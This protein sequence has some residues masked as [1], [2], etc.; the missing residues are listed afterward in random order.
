MTE[1]V[2]ATVYA[3]DNLVSY[4][5]TI[6]KAK[7]AVPANHPPPEVAYWELA[8]KFSDPCAQSM[9]CDYLAE[10]LSL[11]VVISHIPR[12]H[13]QVSGDGVVQRTGSTF[14]PASDKAYGSLYGSLIAAREASLE[15]MLSRGREVIKDKTA[16]CYALWAL[17]KPLEESCCGGCGEFWQGCTCNGGCDTSSVLSYLVG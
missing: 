16:E 14:I 11:S 3:L 9:W 1:Y 2:P 13:A 4:Q 5:G 17:L 8:P 12:I 7:Q 6:Y 15:N 10:Y